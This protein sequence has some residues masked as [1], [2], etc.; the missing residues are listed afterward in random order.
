[1]LKAELVVDFDRPHSNL[2][3]EQIDQ[4]GEFV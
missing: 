4:V 1:M 2:L 3:K